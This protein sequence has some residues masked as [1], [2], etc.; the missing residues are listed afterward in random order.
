M[1]NFPFF[2]KYAEFVTHN[3]NIS[4]DNSNG[5]WIRNQ[6]EKLRKKLALRLLDDINADITTI[7]DEDMES[8]KL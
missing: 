1:V 4:N 8:A 5:R 6:N 2:E 3:Y 7:T